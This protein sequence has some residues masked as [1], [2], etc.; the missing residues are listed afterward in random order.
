MNFALKSGGF[1]KRMK[2]G[3]YEFRR[4]RLYTKS[5][6][7]VKIYD[8]KAKIG[9][10]SFLVRN[11]GDIT[12][13]EL[14]YIDEEVE[15]GDTIATIYFDDDSLEIYSPLSGVIINLNDNVEYDPDLLL[16]DN[17]DEG[18]LVELALSNKKDAKKLLS[19]EEAEEWFKAEIEKERS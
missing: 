15:E 10:D 13:A 14:A 3:G 8:D 11:L 1:L 7:W 4:D 17:Y 16:K 2:I 9:L 19:G 18:W 12:N 5:H 6:L